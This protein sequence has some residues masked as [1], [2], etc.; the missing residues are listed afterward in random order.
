MNTRIKEGRCPEEIANQRCNG[1]LVNK[2]GV[3]Q[4]LNCGFKVPAKRKTDNQLK[5]ESEWAK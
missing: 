5:P 3:V 4:C 1:F 2:D